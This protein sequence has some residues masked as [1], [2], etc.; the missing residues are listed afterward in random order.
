MATTPEAAGEKLRRP[1][2]KEQRAEI[3]LASMT[4]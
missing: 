1:M 2:I 3:E 4:S